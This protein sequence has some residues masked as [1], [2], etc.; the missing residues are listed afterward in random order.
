[1]TGPPQPLPEHDRAAL[2]NDLGRMTMP[3]M[4]VIGGDSAFVSAGDRREVLRRLP[5]VRIE[6]VLEAGHSVQSDQPKAL[7]G[8]HR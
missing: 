7:S 2:W 8:P 3:V 4:L 5:S 6:T 1:M